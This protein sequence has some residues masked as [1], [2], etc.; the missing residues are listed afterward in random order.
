MLLH[1]SSFT[2]TCCQLHIF[3][4]NDVG[5]VFVN[6][7]VVPLFCFDPRLFGTTRLGNPKTGPFRSKFLLES[8]DALQTA[9]QGMGSDLLTTNSGPEHTMSGGSPSV[10]HTERVCSC[11]AYMTPGDH[12][13]ELRPCSAA[14]CE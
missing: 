6:A 13:I 11:A 9:L 8:V 5:S 4:A 3:V 12:A 14:G 7:Q 2:Y 1:G 10:C